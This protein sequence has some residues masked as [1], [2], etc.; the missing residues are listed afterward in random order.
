MSRQHKLLWAS[1][2][3]IVNTRNMW[4]SKT[5]GYK[6]LRMVQKA[7]SDLEGM[8]KKTQASFLFKDLQIRMEQNSSWC[9]EGKKD[10]FL[11]EANKGYSRR[12]ESQ[13]A[14]GEKTRQVGI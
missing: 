11:S 6:H 13:L 7:L 12:K 14:W 9:L 4:Y 10:T 2:L 3:H 1:R 8:V 5:Y